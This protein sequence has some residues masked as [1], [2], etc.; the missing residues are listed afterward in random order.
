MQ[1]I[2]LVVG[3]AHPELGALLHDVGEHAATQ[4]HHVLPP[5]RVFD[6]DRGGGVGKRREKRERERGVRQCK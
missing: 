3:F 2:N 5:R 1:E 6:P 4:E